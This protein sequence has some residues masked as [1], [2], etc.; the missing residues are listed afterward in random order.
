MFPHSLESLKHSVIKLNRKNKESGDFLFL[1]VSFHKLKNMFLNFS[2]LTVQFFFCPEMLHEMQ[3]KF[4]YWAKTKF[5]MFF[6]LKF[7]CVT[8]F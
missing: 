2:S 1:Q 4:W 7:L 8:F 6:S 3:I 5:V